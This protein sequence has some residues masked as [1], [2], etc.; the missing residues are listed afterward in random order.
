MAKYQALLTSYGSGRTGL[1]AR[2]AT[3]IQKLLGER[4]TVVI[5]GLKLT[6][7]IVRLRERLKGLATTL[8]RLMSCESFKRSL[9]S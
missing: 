7:T 8:Y 1:R 5:P 6:N 3:D 2:A 4:G 9:T